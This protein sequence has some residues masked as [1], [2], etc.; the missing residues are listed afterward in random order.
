M[1]RRLW[2]WATHPVVRLVLALV[3][4]IY[5]GV[6]V[7]RTAARVH[8]LEARVKHQQQEIDVLKR[9]Q[10]M[11]RALTLVSGA[12]AMSTVESWR[13][14]QYADLYAELEMDQTE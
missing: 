8:W 4:A 13:N 12:V 3:V 2:C 11:M 5:L 9:R 7:G 1:M 10:G 14:P 6:M